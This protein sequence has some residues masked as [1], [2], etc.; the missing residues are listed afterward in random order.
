MK[1]DVVVIGGGPAGMSTALAAGRGK[2]KVTLIDEEKPRNAV[3]REAHGFITRDGIEPHNFREKGRE[4]LLKYPNVS[5]ESGRVEAITKLTDGSFNI[6]TERKV[7]LHTKNVV[8]ATGLKES[9]PDVQ[10]IGAYYGKSV[11]SCPFCDGW[12]MK[13]Q[14]LFL[15]IESSEVMH[16]IQLVNNWTDDLIILT[17]GH[18]FIDEDYKKTLEAYH[19]NLI[20][21][22]IVAF[23]GDNGQL[24]SISFA[25]DESVQR[26][27]GFCATKLN[28]TLPFIENLQIDVNDLGYIETDMMGHTNVPRVYATGEIANGPSQ[29]IISASQGHMTGMG[30][31]VDTATYTYPDL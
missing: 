9:L 27:G 18:Q 19:I 2:L 5:I 17:N 21:D 11:F 8:L 7:N 4:D 16:M 10:G 1:L 13:D 22:K 12:E 20:E 29:L 31:I 14:P 28:N 24:Q 6:I 23:N 30:I 3:T 15:L 26:S 25:N